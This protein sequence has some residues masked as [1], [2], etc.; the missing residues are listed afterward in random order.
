MSCEVLSQNSCV[1]VGVVTTDDNYCS[2]AVLLANISN[3]S[4]LLVGLQFGSAGTDDVETAGISV[5]VDVFVIKD[6]IAVFDQ[7]AGAAL[8]A[9]QNVFRVGSFQSIV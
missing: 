8:E 3:D 2:D 6:Y 5:L 7:T 9:V 4:E 1:G